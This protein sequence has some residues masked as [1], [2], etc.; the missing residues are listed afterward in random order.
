MI[1]VTIFKGV[2]MTMC[3]PVLNEE[4]ERAIKSFQLEFNALID[5][6][7]SH[8]DFLLLANKYIHDYPDLAFVGGDCTPVYVKTY[9]EQ[10]INNRQKKRGGKRKGAG[11][12]K[13]E[14]SSPVRVPNSLHPLIYLLKEIHEEGYS[15][16]NNIN[17][18]IELIRNKNAENQLNLI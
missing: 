5:E 13:K 16:E 11:R 2:S 6:G 3:K 17:K 18:I 7:K 1:F 8:D 14:S 12:K 15:D 9:C 4:L 10:E